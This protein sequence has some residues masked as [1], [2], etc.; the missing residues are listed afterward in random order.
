MASSSMTSHYN[1]KAYQRC[2]TLKA[3]RTRK[4]L[5]RV[6]RD[7]RYDVCQHGFRAAGVAVTDEQ[8]R[9]VIERKRCCTGNC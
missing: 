6:A 9:A 4:G 1:S 3:S 7:G 2:Y 5:L 8:L